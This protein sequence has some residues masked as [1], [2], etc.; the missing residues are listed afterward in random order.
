MK[1]RAAE[2]IQHIP[3]GYGTT[4]V[5]AMPVDP[6]RLYAYWEITD[7]DL[8]KARAGFPESVDTRLVLRIFDTTGRIFDGTNAH[9]SFDVVIQR[10]DRQWFLNLNRP[11]STAVVEVG[12]V[13][14]QG[15]YVAMARS[16]PVDFPRREPAPPSDPQWRIAEESAEGPGG[17]Q[18]VEL[19]PP[20]SGTSPR[21]SHEVPRRNTG[22]GNPAGVEARTGGSSEDRLAGREGHGGGSEDRLRDNGK[23]RES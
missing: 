22:K 7:A 4:R 15:R 14:A 11:Q 9:H 21:M 20:P 2:P 19:K 3:W 8:E 17:E 1:K 12:M 16:K 23:S 5:T 6:E 18:R 13:G 10:S